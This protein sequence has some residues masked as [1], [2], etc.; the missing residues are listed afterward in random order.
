M[1]KQI[2][3]L[4]TFIAIISLFEQVSASGIVSP[5]WPGNPNKVVPGE[6]GSVTMTIQNMVGEEDLTFKVTLLRNDENIA[7]VD[8]KEY[9]VPANTADTQVLLRYEIPEN[10]APGK[11]Y[12]VTVSFETVTSGEGGGVTMGTGMDMTIPFEVVAQTEPSQS[13]PTSAIGLSISAYLAILTAVFIIVILVILV[14]RKR[15][16]AIC[17]N[18]PLR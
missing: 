18:M 9:S 15:K 12:T 10:V 14:T 2:I 16:K 4:I 7:S 1:K 6:E 5:F 13:P 8:E 11:T 17:I 3:I